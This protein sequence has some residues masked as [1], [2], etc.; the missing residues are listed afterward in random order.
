MARRDF[1]GLRR[2]DGARA[3]DATEAIK[4]CRSHDKMFHYCKR[5]GSAHHAAYTM[6][7]QIKLQLK[8]ERR[9]IS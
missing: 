1:C 6:T 4:I 5:T 7:T 8:T 3:A 9:N 2:A